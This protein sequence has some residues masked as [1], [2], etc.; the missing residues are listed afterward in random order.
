MEEECKCPT[1]CPAWMTIY[2]DLMSLLLT[3]FILLVSMSDMDKQKIDIGFQSLR[4]AFA[5]MSPSQNT[6]YVGTK[7]FNKVFVPTPVME[8]KSGDIKGKKTDENKGSGDQVSKN[9]SNEVQENGSQSPMLQQIQELKQQLEIQK[10]KLQSDSLND[11]KKENQKSAFKQLQSKAV[12]EL[13]KKLMS[14]LQS[15]IN[16]GAFEYKVDDNKIIIEYPEKGTFNSGSA[17]LSEKM[18]KTTQK[19]A[20]LLQGQNISIK[21]SGFTD[22]IPIKSGRYRSNWDLSAMRASSVANEFLRFVKFSPEQVEIRGYGEGF[23]KASN[24]TK[25]GR[26]ENRRVEILIK[27]KGNKFKY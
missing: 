27:P 14:S 26:S 9:G 22:N 2:S 13:N 6:S 8:P 16:K 11:T 3:F 18:K 21:I 19:I 1:P 25:E 23:P 15:D 4:E 10:N 17:E 7:D 5:G 24:A 12:Q 20:F